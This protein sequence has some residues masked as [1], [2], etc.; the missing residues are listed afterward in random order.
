MSLSVTGTIIAI[1]PEVQVNVSLNKREFAVQ[2]ANR[3]VSESLKFE[4]VLDRTA[5]I[6]PFNVGD[7]VKVSYNVLGRNTIP[8][9][10]TTYVNTLE[11]Y[12]VT[13]SFTASPVDPLTDP[14]PVQDF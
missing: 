6:V 3:G 4:L 11:A 13:P 1:F 10:A 5:L 12:A 2:E 7:S 8:T 14:A 9:D